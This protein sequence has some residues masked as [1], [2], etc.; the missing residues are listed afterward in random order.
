MHVWGC[1]HPRMHVCSGGETVKKEDCM[2]ALLSLSMML[3][4][5]PF[6]LTCQFEP[7]VC[8][9]HADI[10]ILLSERYIVS[11]LVDCESSTSIDKETHRRVK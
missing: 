3:L 1:L 2:A 6:V 4:A 9:Y 5:K 10:P 8:A 7:A 11:L